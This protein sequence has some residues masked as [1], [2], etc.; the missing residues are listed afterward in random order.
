M[1]KLTVRNNRKLACSVLVVVCNY[2]PYVVNS[3]LGPF[4]L[5]LTAPRGTLK[6]I[7][8]FNNKQFHTGVKDSD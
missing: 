2:A 5:D 4:A 6:S 1:L 8:I 3:Q 7:N